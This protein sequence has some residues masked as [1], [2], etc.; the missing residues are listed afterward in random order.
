MTNAKTIETQ[1]TK[2]VG[3]TSQTVKGR[4]LAFLKKHVK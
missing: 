1:H 3:A 2:K 4:P